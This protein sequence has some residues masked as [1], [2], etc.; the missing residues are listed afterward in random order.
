MNKKGYSL[1]G[2]AEGILLSVLFVLILSVLVIGGLNNMYSKN[3]DVGLGTNSTLEAF[4]DYQATQQSKIE[5]GEAEFTSS[6]GLTLKSSWELT[7]A[8][9]STIWSFFA[10]G[11]IES[12][13]SF[14]HLPMEVALVG[15]ILYFISLGFAIMY[16]LF[17]VKP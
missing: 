1:S 9:L 14:M 8:T 7:K 2:W 12:I 11:W 3:Y 4:K 17:K 16:I 15:R 13:V 5:G 6:Q 10:G